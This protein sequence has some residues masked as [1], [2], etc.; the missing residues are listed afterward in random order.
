[1]SFADRVRAHSE[2][3][4]L[5]AGEKET[6]R[7]QREA[8]IAEAL[9]ESKLQCSPL[10]AELGEA[11]NVLVG[12]YSPTLKV[13][14]PGS[15]PIRKHFVGWSFNGP[16]KPRSMPLRGPD[17]LVADTGRAGIQAGRFLGERHDSYNVGE[18]ESVDL[19]VNTRSSYLIDRTSNRGRLYVRY[20][21]VE[22]LEAWLD[23]IARYVADAVG[24]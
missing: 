18:L 17:L 15:F 21:M 16:S 2:A 10:V 1:M 8:A 23:G 24:K 4:Q 22:C 7:V 11:I 9:R 13:S 6:S 3:Q 5:S 19:A 20:A 14:I 12:S